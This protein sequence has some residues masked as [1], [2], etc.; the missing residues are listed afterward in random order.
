MQLVQRAS[1][2]EVERDAPAQEV[3][4]GV[5]SLI[6]AVRC[7]EHRHLWPDGGLR[8][9]DASVLGVLAKDGEQRGGEIAGKLGVDASVVSR[10]VSALE[11]DGLVSRR[12]DPADARVSLVQLSEP[13][14]DR[15]HALYAGY[16]RQLRS[17]LADWDDDELAAAAATLRRVAIAITEAA[18]FAKHSNLSTGD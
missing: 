13:G 4:E 11:A 7:I 1:V 16:S 10:Q 2:P 5:S 8:R 6:R 18:E 12:P 9:A 15:L 14:R 3:L 17:A